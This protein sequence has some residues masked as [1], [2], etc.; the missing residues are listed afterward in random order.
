MMSASG[1]AWRHLSLRRRESR[2]GVV[3]GWVER[4]LLWS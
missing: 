3:R 1:L 2:F 4:A